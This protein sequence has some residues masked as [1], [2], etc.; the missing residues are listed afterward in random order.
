MECCVYIKYWLT[1]GRWWWRLGLVPHPPPGW[2][3]IWPLTQGMPTANYPHGGP[4]YT[5]HPPH[6][7]HWEMPSGEQGTYYHFLKG[8]RPTGYPWTTTLKGRERYSS[9]IM[10]LEESRLPRLEWAPSLTTS[11]KMEATPLGAY[12]PG[13]AY[14]ACSMLLA[15]SFNV[16]H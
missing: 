2:V 9:W 13:H 11:P 12:I 16:G 4:I 1:G 10:E 5:L 7:S 3:S 6:L 8:D 14:P 15:N